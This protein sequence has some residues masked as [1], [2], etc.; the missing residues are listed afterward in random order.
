M[1]EKR[2]KSISIYTEKSI[3]DF[4]NPFL[5]KFPFSNSNLNDIYEKYAPWE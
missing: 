2:G 4:K 1:I 3:L 5:K